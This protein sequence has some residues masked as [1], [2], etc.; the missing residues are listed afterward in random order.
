MRKTTILTTIILLTL[1][2]FTGI[3]S[4]AGPNYMGF[5]RANPHVTVTDSFNV[6]AWVDVDSQIDTAAVDNLTYLPAGILHYTSTAQGDLFSGTTMWLTPT[7]IDD[8]N[9]YVKPIVWSYADEMAHMFDETTFTVAIGDCEDMS[10]LC[11]TLYLAAGFE[12]A[13]VSPPEHVALLIWLPEYD[14]ANYYW[15]IPGDGKEYG[16]IWVEAT[17]EQNSLGWTP[18]DFADGEWE[19]FLLGFSIFD[20]DISP[21]YPN[22]EDEVHVRADIVSARGSINQILLNYSITGVEYVTPMVA[23][24]N[25]YEA[26]IPKQPDGTKVEGAVSASDSYGFYREYIFEYVV[27]SSFDGFDNF[28]IQLPPYLIE[29]AVVIFVFFLLGIL[30]RLRRR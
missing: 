30:S 11:S 28:D 4:S 6:I 15:D 7:V 27:G 13:L 10:F 5:Y 20:V 2:P 8:T 25:I 9:G 26:L 3:V 24:G 23:E 22:A 29:T 17:G 14:N 18:P 21:G 12:V 1:V 16:W 19:V